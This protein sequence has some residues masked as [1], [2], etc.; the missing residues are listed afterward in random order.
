MER[1]VLDVKGMSCMH[2]VSAVKRALGS[3][4]GVKQTD[5]VLATGKVMVE[6]DPTKVS[7]E[8]M[9]KVISEAGYT[10]A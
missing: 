7:A 4:D 3:I 9:K 10:V 6:Y 2:C 8:N 1:V 5:V